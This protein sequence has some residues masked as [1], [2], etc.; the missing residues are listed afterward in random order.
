MDENRVDFNLRVFH[1]HVK[2]KPSI[3]LIFQSLTK[4]KLFILRVRAYESAVEIT[5]NHPLKS[6]KTE[7]LLAHLIYRIW[8]ITWEIFYSF[9]F[10]LLVTRIWRLKHRDFAFFRKKKQSVFIDAQGLGNRNRVTVKVEHMVSSEF[11]L[12]KAI[13]QVDVL[14]LSVISKSQGK[15]NRS[16]FPNPSWTK[17]ALGF[18]WKTLCLEL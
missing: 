8:K 3:F 14:I 7:Q 5:G 16:S 18:F 6:K 9:S 11:E 13:F 17:Q 12:D 15:C 1:T 2:N 10:R 4:Y